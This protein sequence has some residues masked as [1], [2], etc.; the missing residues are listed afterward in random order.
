VVTC[1]S[2]P[3]P[4]GPAWAKCTVTVTDDSILP[5]SNIQCT[6]NTRTS[7]DQIPCRV[8]GITTGSFKVEMQTGTTAMWLAFTPAQ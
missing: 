7:D 4:R 5:N 3:E 2:A 6:Y 1:G 8:F